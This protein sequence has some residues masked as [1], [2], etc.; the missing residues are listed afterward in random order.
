MNR[1]R[2]TCTGFDW[3][4]ESNRRKGRKSNEQR[5][6]NAERLEENGR[7]PI[8]QLRGRGQVFLDLRGWERLHDGRLG[9]S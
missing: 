8:R 2:V 5:W 6:E 7:E 1:N 3:S 9:S 4:V